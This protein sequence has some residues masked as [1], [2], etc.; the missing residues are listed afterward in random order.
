MY[1]YFTNVLTI[2]KQKRKS[3]V[4]KF[5][6]SALICL[7]LAIIFGLFLVRNLNVQTT[8]IQQAFFQSHIAFGV[9][10]WFSLLTFG[11]SY[12]L[13]PM[14]SISR[15]YTHNKAK[16]VFSYHITG[17]L[18]IITSFWI[19]HLTIQKIG[20]LFLLIGFSFFI[21]DI[22]NILQRRLRK[23]LDIPFLFV[24]LA[25]LIGFIIHITAWII[26]FFQPTT[27]IVWNWLIFIYFTGWI[28]C[29]IL[30]YLY[31]RLPM[32]LISQQKISTVTTMINEPLI[33]TIFMSF[34]IGII[35]LIIALFH[36]LLLSFLSFK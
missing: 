6:L 1:I 29:S 3:T 33:V 19:E 4:T 5:V 22:Y 8:H 28:A 21:Y 17:L 20:W 16:H 32:L 35:E 9:S 14:F 30:E 24:L 25:I 2:G 15:G 31:K 27:P 18:F 11:F 26:S 34:I 13:V 10:G 23:K 7:F 12:Q 36:K